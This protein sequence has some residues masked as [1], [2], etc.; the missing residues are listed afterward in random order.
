MFLTKN[1]LI[2][3]IQSFIDQTF[4]REWRK[5]Q[6][7]LDGKKSEEDWLVR[8]KNFF[9]KDVKEFKTFLKFMSFDCSLNKESNQCRRF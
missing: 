5:E 9:S 2:S 4:Y 3:E 7:A 1:E 8:G 6:E